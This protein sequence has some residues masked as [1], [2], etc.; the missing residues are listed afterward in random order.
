MPSV[1]SS[2]KRI[3]CLR[4]PGWPVQRLIV[5]RERLLED[6]QLKKTESKPESSPPLPPLR[7]R[8][9]VLFHRDSR[10]GQLVAAASPLAMRCGIAHAMPL[11]EAKSLLRY[12]TGVRYATGGATG[13]SNTA[14]N[15]NG[16][17]HI[18]EHDPE[19]DL[20]ELKKLALSLDEFSPMIGLEQSEQ[21][22]CI[23]M[24]ITG[25]A[26]LF[27]DEYQLARG[28]ALHCS[29]AGYFV[30]IG[31]ANTVAFARAASRIQAPG[32]SSN[33][34]PAQNSGESSEGRAG[35][36]SIHISHPDLL[37]ALPV[38]DLRLEAVTI[39][40]LHQLGILRVGDLQQ[41]ARRDLR[42]RFGNEILRRLD[43]MTGAIDEPVVALQR[44]P[45]YQAEQFIEFPTND[46]E[47]I[48]VIVRRLV[49]DICKQ[50]RARQQGAL[51]WSFRL[52][53]TEHA[54]LDFQ[55]NLFQPA[56]T[57]EH[58]MQL[59]S[60]QLEQVLQPHTRRK[61]TRPVK[62][63]YLKGRRPAGGNRNTQSESLSEEMPDEKTPREKTPQE[64][65]R[66]IKSPDEKTPRTKSPDLA[67]PAA[68]LT[69]SHTSFRR[70]TTLA[71]QEITVSVT[72]CVLLA[73]RQRKLFDDNPRL[74]KQALAQ[75]INQLTC[76]LG[77]EQ[78]LYPV[79]RAEALPEYAVR[80]RPLVDPARRR[81]RSA[82][83]ARSHSH[84][85]ARPL[86]LL[87]PPVPLEGC[88]LQTQ[89]GTPPGNDRD[90]CL[91]SFR[92]PPSARRYTV[93]RTT[94]PERIE[95]G[96]WRGPSRRRDYWQVEAQTGQRFWIFFDL[97]KKG[98]FLHGEF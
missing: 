74:D 71:V 97:K 93:E 9:V 30:R 84:V 77:P 55:V 20:A 81:K 25:I 12:A 24:D 13:D 48:E 96:W 1:A 90:Q 54:P 50:M 44:P 7:R 36:C 27:G 18:F 22:A 62:A 11:S 34:S 87:H 66:G 32:E 67:S 37:S 75:L 91:H 53:C 43:Q 19:A 46:R 51:Q 80:L 35:S 85:M 21:P 8:H 86:R 17:F 78:V 4:L 47:T 3:L 5:A 57:I 40:T 52:W 95:S 16:N 60:M 73:G 23:L 58:V 45:E 76:R 28:I 41:L 63:A 6:R 94:G 33:E 83:K 42:S 49:L 14:Q 29:S 88:E 38:S 39:D 56:A 89:T 69:S 98:W 64:K 65:T 10:R 61:K 68:D 79:L 72:S 70:Y 82:G 59:V 31:I 2:G 92:I 15:G 26:R